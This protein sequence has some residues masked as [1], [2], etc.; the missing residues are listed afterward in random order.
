MNKVIETNWYFKDLDEF[1]AVY[2]KYSYKFIFELCYE[3]FVRIMDKIFELSTYCIGQ[4]QVASASVNL[5][6][7]TAVVWPV[8]E[9]KVAP[10]WQK[11][12]GDA[13]ANHLTNCGFKS[14]LRGAFS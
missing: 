2:Y 8:S 6:T 12:V 1:I 11:I 7:E 14:N 13:L 4:P 5:T 3:P 10:N 9:A